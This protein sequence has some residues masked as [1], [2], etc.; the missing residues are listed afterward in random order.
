[1]TDPIRRL[2]H[3]YADAV[4]ADDADRWS[5]TW[6][7]DAVWEMGAMSWTGRA[8]IVEAWIQA[9]A[10]FEQVIHIVHNGVADLDPDTGSGDG[11]W[12]VAEY[13]KPTSG[14]P[15]QLLACYDDEYV[16]VDG[17]WVFGSRRLK[18]LYSG[19]PDLTG[20]FGGP[21]GPPDTP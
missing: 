19:P 18:R 13:L 6:A 7:P 1:V 2:V 8:D 5:A 9:M 12:Y 10:R 21:P 20:K 17:V 15:S 16:H 11:R 4:C 3:Q 14:D